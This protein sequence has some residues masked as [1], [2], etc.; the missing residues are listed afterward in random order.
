MRA[1]RQRKA[2]QPATGNR[3]MTNGGHIRALLSFVNKSSAP[4]C[5]LA[6]NHAL[7]RGLRI[8]ENPYKS[9]I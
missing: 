9:M 8:Q 3:P 5:W 6:N 2:P 7:L 1:G 4:F